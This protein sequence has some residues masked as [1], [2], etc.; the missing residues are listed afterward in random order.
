MITAQQIRAGRALVRWS[1]QELADGTEL[2]LST[3]QRM[4][5]GDGIPSASAPNL[6]KVQAALEGAGVVFLDATGEHGPGV[7]VRLPKAKR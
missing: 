2:G 5:S 3:V 4:E 7:A 6:A 1:A